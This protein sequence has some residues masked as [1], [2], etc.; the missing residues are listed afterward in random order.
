MTS[1]VGRVSSHIWLLEQ[2]LK[3][4]TIS[5]CGNKLHS[6]KAVGEKSG[7]RGE[8]EKDRKNSQIGGV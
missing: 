2:T 1:Q 3:E 7:K 5:N 8:E 4:Q 6:Q